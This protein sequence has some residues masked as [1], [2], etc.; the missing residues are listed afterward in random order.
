[1]EQEIADT[2]QEVRRDGTSGQRHLLRHFEGPDSARS[3]A[4]SYAA[5]SRWQ[6]A[7]LEEQLAKL[8]E[9]KPA[10]MTKEEQARVQQART[11]G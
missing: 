1:M 6:V 8:K 10:T 2:A 3:P 5:L 9:E 4:L 7:Q 11:S